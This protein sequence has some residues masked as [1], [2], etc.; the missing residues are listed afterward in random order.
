MQRG[1]IDTNLVLRFLVNDDP[2]KVKRVEKLLQNKRDQNILL[3]TVVA[4]IVWVLQ[5]YYSLEKLEIIE[6]IRALIHIDSIDCNTG[7]I[8][9]ALTLWKNNA[10]AYIDAYLVATAEHKNMP[11]YTYDKRLHGL[12][13]IM[14]KEP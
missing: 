10:I 3:D 9:R 4:E 2:Q 6:K 14:C 8:D 13:F 11:L 7:I 12:K 5:S 1:I